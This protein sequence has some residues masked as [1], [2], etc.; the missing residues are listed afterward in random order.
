[1]AFSIKLFCILQLGA[2]EGKNYD[3]CNDELLCKYLFY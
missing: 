2:G 1:M 3:I